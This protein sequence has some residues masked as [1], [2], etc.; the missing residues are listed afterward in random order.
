[1]IGGKALVRDLHELRRVHLVIHHIEPPALRGWRV[2][3]RLGPGLGRRQIER[4]DVNLD[5]ELGAD[6]GP[7]EPEGA[8][9]DNGAEGRGSVSYIA[10]KR[11]NSQ[12]QGN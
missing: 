6:T 7:I 3:Y 12:D 8:A 1:V 2:Q 9:G 11:R 4:A 5:E 10:A